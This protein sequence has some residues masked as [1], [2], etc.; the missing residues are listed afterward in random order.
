MDKLLEDYDGLVQKLEQRKRLIILQRVHRT[1]P[2]DF[3]MMEHGLLA[4]LKEID[5]ANQQLDIEHQ[6]NIVERFG[7]WGKKYM[8]NKNEIPAALSSP[9]K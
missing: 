2:A 5:E 7:I 8:M 4:K 6:I 3:V 9:R 1:L